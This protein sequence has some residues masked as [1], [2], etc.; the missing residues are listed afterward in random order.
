M[1]CDR[2]EEGLLIDFAL[3][4]TDEAGSLAIRQ[5][6][7]V[8]DSC[9]RHV[10]SLEAILQQESSAAPPTASINRLVPLLAKQARAQRPTWSWSLLW[11]HPTMAA[12][13]LALLA[14]FFSAGYVQGNLVGRR[15]AEPRESISIAAPAL[16]APPDL[17]PL[18]AQVQ[19]AEWSS[20]WGLGDHDSIQSTFM[21]VDSL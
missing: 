5:H 11:H 17:G 21:P 16:P 3:T 2:F 19:T 9:R 8:C 18:A 13:S 10:E 14:L 6:L 15:T 20:Q 7:L 4:E 12:A 1:S